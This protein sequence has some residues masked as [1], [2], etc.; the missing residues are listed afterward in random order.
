[1]AKKNSRTQMRLGQ[2]T[3]SLHAGS[4]AAAAGKIRADVDAGALSAYSFLDLS[5]SLSAMLSGISR[6]HGRT[7]DNALNNA[8]GVFYTAILPDSAGGQDIGSTSAEWG[9]IFIGDAK[10]LK[11]GEDQDVTLTHNNAQG[12]L[13]TSANVFGITATD[14]DLTITADGADNQLV[15]KGD[16]ESGTAIH[17]D[18]NAN[19]ASVV[20][21]DA[22][23]LDIDASDKVTIDA[24]A[25]IELTTSTA[26][27]H[28]TL[29]S[30][31]TAGVA[32]LIDANAAAGAILD[33][34]AG[35]LDA[36]VQ[37][38]ANID[39][40]GAVSLQAGAASDFTTSGGAITID[41]KVGV[42]IKEDGTDVLVITTDRDVTL[43]ASGRTVTINSN[44]DV[45]GT[46]TTI[47]TT[48]TQIEDRIIGLGVSGSNGNYSSLD[49]G[50]IFG[51]GEKSSAQAAV[52]YAGAA[53]LFELARYVAAPASSS[54]G[55]ASAYSD[56]K[57]ANLFATNLELAGKLEIPDTD[58]SH[59][60]ELKWNEGDTADRVLN[61]D[62]NQADR[63][64]DLTG[65]LTV[66]AASVV[67]QDLSTDSSAVQFAGLNLSEGNITNV[68]DINADSLSVDDAA[69]GLTID[70]SSANTTKS[71]ILLRD[72]MADALSIM[73]GSN[74]YM[75]F[76]TT[77][78]QET[79]TLSKFVN[80]ED[81]IP[82]AFGG[83]PGGDFRLFYDE[84]GTDKLVLSASVNGG[85]KS[86]LI[87]DGHEVSLEF[88]NNLAKIFAPVPGELK[89]E[90]GTSFAIESNFM[91]LGDGS[92][93]PGALRFQE[94]SGNGTN[95]TQL[96]AGAAIGS[97]VLLKLPITAGSA[98]QVMKLN[99][100]D[101]TQLEF[102]DAGNAAKSVFSGSAG[103]ALAAGGDVSGVAG[104]TSFNMALHSSIT[105]ANLSAAMNVFVNGQLL[106]SGSE[107]ERA[108][109]GVDYAVSGSGNNYKL[110]LAFDL[111][112]DDVVQV[113]VR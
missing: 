89:V 38:A 98:G 92:T 49:T 53:N 39:A 112:V 68:G 87:G 106:M 113:V 73:E 108:A 58:A 40:G 111:E 62:V 74:S 22:G 28:I 85:I 46:T 26:A 6:I 52:R 33:I 57:V 13:L 23:V 32:V 60:L 54:F 47:D 110:K 82:L 30:A 24:A 109:G 36:D 75:R 5:G 21:V 25:E 67:N 31:H 81:D 20:D 9:D 90:A 34:D 14:G 50:L 71:K 72:G 8:A 76:T 97:N 35:I 44:L 48:N 104:L 66:E 56:L 105:D 80:V 29:H 86:F 18:G 27:G 79:I 99:G 15:L 63:T 41:G 2:L 55:V 91:Q 93:G 102:G 103:A 64:I 94:T 88:Q 16:H 83:A 78:N 12:A 77:D 70:F 3:G 43:G 7:G 11:L 37:G 95:Y 65:N 107:T 59:H 100:S 51:F 101:A 45:N 1:M 4:N 61:I 10:S 84:A 19:A 17:I 96:S 69:E 42:N